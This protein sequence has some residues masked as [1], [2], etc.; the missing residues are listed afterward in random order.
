MKEKQKERLQHDKTSICRQIGI[1]QNEES[2][3]V[4]NR[5]EMHSL[6]FGKIQNSKRCA[7]WGECFY[8]IR[9][10]FV[11]AGIRVKY[12]S[13]QYVGVRAPISSLIKRKMT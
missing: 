13:R 9:T 7:G 1:L 2:R 8:P 11:D 12:P 5:K 10:I 4:L 6:I 3:L